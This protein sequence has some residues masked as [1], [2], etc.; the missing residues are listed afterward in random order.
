MGEYEQMEKSKLID[1][2]HNL[3]IVAFISVVFS[4]VSVTACLL[5]FPLVFQ[6]VQTLQANVQSEVEFCKAR[7]RDMWKEML[8]IQQGGGGAA[9]RD[10]PETPFTAFMRVAR[11]VPK[12]EFGQCCTCQQ[13]PDGPPGDDGPGGKDGNPGKDGGPGGPGKDAEEKGV[14]IPIP[15]QCPCQAHPGPKGPL[16]PKGP[17]GPPGENGR[18]GADGVPGGQGPPGPVGP[19]GPAGAKG[20]DGAKG[21]DGKVGPGPKGPAG[22]AGKNGEKGPAGPPGPAGQPGKDGPP[23]PQAAP[24]DGGTPG[25]AG[26]NGPEGPKGE[27]GK[28]G[29]PGSCEHCPPARL[30]PGY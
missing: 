25:N 14:F 5:S 28:P 11:Q 19:P 8:D 23:G 16:G 4:T 30:S 24:G 13:G 26:K 22:P 6:Y 10:G 9:S 18:P 2:H 29:N 15:E 7:S 1:Q 12:S 21:P 17:D 3:R 27:P 20:A